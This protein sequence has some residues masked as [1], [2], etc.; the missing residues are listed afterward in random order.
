MNSHERKIAGIILAAGGSTRMG[1][2]K[3]LLEWH[4]D[5]LIRWVARLTLTAGCSPVMVVTGAHHSGVEAALADLPVE[6]IHNPRWGE[7]Q[8]TS[9]RAGILALPGDIDA[10]MIF[11]G[12]QPQIPLST[13]EEL[14]RIYTESDPPMPILLPAS[15][16]RRGNPVLFDRAMLYEL[17]RLEGDAGARLIFS[18][19]PVRMMAFDDPNLLLDIDVPEDYQKLMELPPPVL[20]S[21][22][23]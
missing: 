18:K 19:Y 23:K 10:A 2:P 15:S 1:S 6:K 4:G 11:L 20:P 13:V 7:G 9:V 5:A 12:D 16:G 3:L 17:T 8:S 21:F 22:N 14:M